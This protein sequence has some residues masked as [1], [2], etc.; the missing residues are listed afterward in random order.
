MAALKNQ[1]VDFVV[2]LNRMVYSHLLI[3]RIGKHGE[4]VVGTSLTGLGTSGC[5]E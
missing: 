3:Q 4:N 2:T 5:F 1:H